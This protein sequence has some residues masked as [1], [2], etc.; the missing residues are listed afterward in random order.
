MDCFWLTVPCTVSESDRACD[1]VMDTLKKITPCRFSTL[2]TLCWTETGALTS[3]HMTSKLSR[4]SYI[5]QYTIF[6]FLFFFFF[7]TINPEW[8]HCPL[9][10]KYRLFAFLLNTSREKSLHLKLL[11]WLCIVPVP[12]LTTYY[13]WLEQRG[14]V[15]ICVI[16]LQPEDLCSISPDNQYPTY[17]G[18]LHQDFL[19]ATGLH[20]WRDAG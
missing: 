14:G 6:L 8:E 16:V 7:V 10:P 9:T 20:L 17:R 15:A 11:V 5:F 1:A 13:R 18:A 4:G 12:H 3:P 2:P 19:Q